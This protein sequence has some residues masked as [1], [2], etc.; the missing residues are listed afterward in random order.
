MLTNNVLTWALVVIRPD[1]PVIN[2]PN[3]TVVVGNK[4]IVIY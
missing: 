2:D 4:T 1:D 3:V